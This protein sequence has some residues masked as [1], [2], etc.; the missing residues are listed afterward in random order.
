VRRQVAQGL[1]VTRRWIIAEDFGQVSAGGRDASAFLWGITRGDE[2]QRVTRCGSRSPT[3]S[4]SRRRRYQSPNAAYEPREVQRN[5]VAATTRALEQRPLWRARGSNYD[6]RLPRIDS[7]PFY[8]GRSIEPRTRS[9][10]RPR[11]APSKWRALAGVERARA[12]CRNRWARAR[13]RHGWLFGYR[14]PRPRCVGRRF[15]CLGEKADRALGELIRPLVPKPPG[16]GMPSIDTLVRGP[17]YLEP[18]PGPGT[19]STSS[20]RRCSLR[21]G[22]SAAI[23]GFLSLFVRASIGGFSLQ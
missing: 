19:N 12:P 18:R 23:T 21:L 3:A 8:R 5:P 15:R 10:V 17:G 11:W 13:P 1:P 9:K 14:W 7:I 6:D 22:T 4:G 16:Q 2:T 20:R